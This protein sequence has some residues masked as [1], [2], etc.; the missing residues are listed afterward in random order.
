[1]DVSKT[2]PSIWT[3]LFSYGFYYPW[4]PS[5]KQKKMMKNLIKSIVFLFP[6]CI[7]Q[8][9][10]TF[11]IED[12]PCR[13]NK[14]VLANKATLTQWLYLFRNYVN[15]KK[16]LVGELP[17]TYVVPTYIE[18]SKYYADNFRVKSNTDL[19]PHEKPESI[20]NELMERSRN[21]VKSAFYNEQT[22]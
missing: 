9:S 1:M 14:N 6:C 19:Y 13:L 16:Y 22:K 8:H 7:C 12:S 3:T 15:R 5:M 11:F 21:K 18:V 10:A 20:N 4:D 2:G 17:D